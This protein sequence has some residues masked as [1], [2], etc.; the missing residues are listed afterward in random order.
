M[1][2]IL[3]IAFLLVASNSFGAV[4]AH[5][6]PDTGGFGTGSSTEFPDACLPKSIDAMA[7]DFNKRFKPMEFGEAIGGGAGGK[8]TPAKDFAFNQ[9][10]DQVG[11]KLLYQVFSSPDTR[12]FIGGYGVSTDG[13]HGGKHKDILRGVFQLQMPDGAIVKVLAGFRPD[14]KTGKLKFVDGPDSLRIWVGRPKTPL[15]AMSYETKVSDTGVITNMDPTDYRAKDAPVA[16]A[17]ANCVRCHADTAN[18]GGRSTDYE[19]F[20]PLEATFGTPTHKEDWNRIYKGELKK[21][22]SGIQKMIAA[23]DK[24]PEPP[25]WPI[26]FLAKQAEQ[27]KTFQLKG[28]L[29]V[30]KQRC[31]DNARKP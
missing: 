2:K 18:K 4:A 5:E 16:A 9:A 19:A 26:K 27:P 20:H 22:E 3:Q 14:K 21:K 10:M 1:K 23:F 6:D 12:F 11:S 24:E 31:V 30:L 8:S 13:F 7:K 28:I 17:P 15:L 25:M 29:D